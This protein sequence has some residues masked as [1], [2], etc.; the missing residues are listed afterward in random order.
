MKSIGSEDKE[1]VFA[2]RPVPRK[3]YEEDSDLEADQ[4]EEQDC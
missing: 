3:I 1:M 2:P 4:D